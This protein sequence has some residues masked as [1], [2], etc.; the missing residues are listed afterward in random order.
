MEWSQMS[1]MEKEFRK[2][3]HLIRNSGNIPVM[4]GNLFT[5]REFRITLY[6]HLISFY[7]AWAQVPEVHQAAAVA[8]YTGLT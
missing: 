2:G 6:C 5:K 7:V 1:Q 8:G 4:P 3:C